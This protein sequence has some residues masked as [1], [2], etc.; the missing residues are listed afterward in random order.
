[1]L[2]GFVGPVV[3]AYVLL[4]VKDTNTLNEIGFCFFGS[5]PQTAAL[6]WVPIL[7]EIVMMVALTRLLLHQRG[8][9]RLIGYGM[10]V[11]GVLLVGLY[12]TPYYISGLIHTVHD[13]I[14]TALFFSEFVLGTWVLVTVKFD[15]VGLALWVAALTGDLLAEL[16]FVDWIGGLM[17]A[18]QVIAQVGFMGLLIRGL[19]VMEARGK[20]RGAGT[21]LPQQLLKRRRRR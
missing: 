20:Y 6:Y 4:P 12:V 14:A 18:G 1:M 8:N 15:R 17:F 10:A 16:T 3:L 11:S 9:L 21:K 5:L 7:V 19:D 2:A 13:D